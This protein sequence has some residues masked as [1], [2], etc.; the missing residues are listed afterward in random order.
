MERVSGLIRKKPAD[1]QSDDE[2]DGQDEA[3]SS[4]EADDFEVLEKIKTSS[5]NGNGKAMKRGK[6]N[7]RGR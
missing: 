6:K 3:D 4:E 1:G 2:F 7:V 5:Q